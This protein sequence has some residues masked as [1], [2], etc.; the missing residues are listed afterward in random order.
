MP[1]V[2]TGRWATRVREWRTRG[3]DANARSGNA[4]QWETMTLTDAVAR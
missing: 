4:A 3:R 2:R 1:A